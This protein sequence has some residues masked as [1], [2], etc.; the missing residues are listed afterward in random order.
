MK[1]TNNEIRSDNSIGI[2]GTRMISEALKSNSTLAL[3][4]LSR[5]DSILRG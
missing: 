3:L 2:N 5:D 4:D 1:W